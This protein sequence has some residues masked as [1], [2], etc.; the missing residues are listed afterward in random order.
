MR[1]LDGGDRGEGGVGG[2]LE[3]LLV[4]LGLGL[5]GHVEGHEHRAAVVR[6]GVGAVLRL[7]RALDVGDALDLVEAMDDV[8]HRGGDLRIVGLDRALALDEHALA[9]L[10][11][12]VRVVDD[13][14]V[15][16]GL[17]VA[18]LGRLE[19]LLADLAADHG[20]EDDEEDP[21]E[22]G[23]LAMLRR[24]PPARPAR[25]RR[26]RYRPTSRR[27][28]SPSGR[29]PAS[30]AAASTAAAR[31]VSPT[32]CAARSPTPARVPAAWRVS[33][34]WCSPAPSASARTA[35]R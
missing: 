1:L 14:V 23:G 5:A 29:L 35:S 11:G 25:L 21:A 18:H 8:L 2:G 22:D 33:R 9:D 31:A 28:R 19:V 20:R 16:L 26:R 4:L 3:R 7:E 10:V 34:S 30:C 32:R 24:P 17:A 6:D 15:L 12:E 27:R 13:G